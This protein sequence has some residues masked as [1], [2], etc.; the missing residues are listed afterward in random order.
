M[1]TDVLGDSAIILRDL[2]APA[3]QIAEAIQMAELPGV[4][5]AV[6]SYETVGVYFNPDVFDVRFLNELDFSPS[7]TPVTRHQIPVCY[8]MGMDLDEVSAELALS[9]E[10]VIRFHASMDYDCF[11]VGFCPGFPYLGYLPKALSGIPRRSSP[12]VR[13]E[14]GS[15]AITG[16]QTGVYPMVRPGG[17][18]LIGKTPLCLVDVEDAY[19][20]IKAGDKVRFMPIG[21]ADYESLEGERL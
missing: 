19:F 9:N 13:V 12:R 10:E 21:L 5:E 14:P 20:P 4:I 2:P 15:V 16:K 17:W 8:E 3:H 6:A 18:A 7:L 11:A 1:K